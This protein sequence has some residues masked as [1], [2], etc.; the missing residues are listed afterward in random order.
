MFRPLEAVDFTDTCLLV[1][2]CENPSIRCSGVQ[3]IKEGEGFTK[4]DFEAFMKPC[5]KRCETCRYGSK[6]DLR[7]MDVKVLVRMLS[8]T[9]YG[10]YPHVN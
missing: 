4:V 9:V 7:T 3:Y 6:G 8:G 10:D 2:A 5:K 1:L